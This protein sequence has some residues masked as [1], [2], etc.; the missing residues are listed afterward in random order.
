MQ[1]WAPD[2]AG[3]LGPRQRF[4]GQL[5][6]LAKPA[7]CSCWCAARMAAPLSHGTEAQPPLTPGDMA[8]AAGHVGLAA[9][10]AEHSLVQ[11]MKDLNVAPGGPH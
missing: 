2:A 9:F 6:M 10:L 1:T 5:P 8:A 11:L 7:W 3:R 4:T